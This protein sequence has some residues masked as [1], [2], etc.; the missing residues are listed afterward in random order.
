[1]E[2]LVQTNNLTKWYGKHKVVNSVNLSVKKGEIY[3]L[4]GRNGAGKTTVLRL[5]SGLAKP[6]G[7]N[8][9]L[10]EKNGH[11]TIY[12]QN[13]V[14][15]LIENPGVYPNMNAKENIKLKCLAKGISSKNYIT[16]LL[17]NVG[18]SAAGKKKVKHF[19]VGMKQ[20]LGIA[21]ALVGS[22][23][24]VLLD[25]PI[26]GLDPQ[27]MAEIREMISR[28]NRERGITFIISSH[29]LGELSK[30]ATSYGIIEKGELK[31]QILKTELTED[32]EEYFFS[33]TGGVS[34][35]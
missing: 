4:I 8:V 17:E 12:A 16:E 6:T 9:C 22:P 26:N 10:F 14:G 1:M 3:G 7:G 24:L 15:V 19:S 21:L 33:L 35:D 32:L 20:R 18:L 2:V 29:I 11:D 13:R 28:L 31:K 30:I 23:E 34:H 27:G 5:I 25:E